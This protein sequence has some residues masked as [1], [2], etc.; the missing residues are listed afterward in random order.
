M[1]PVDA[2]CWIISVRM[3]A[4]RVNGARAVERWF[5]KVLAAAVS[6]SVATAACASGNDTLPPLT[7][8]VR[9]TF[10]MFD[11]PLGIE[12]GTT[13]LNK[14]QLSGTL[15]GDQFGLDGWSVHAQLFRF[16][17]QSLSRRLGD[18]QTADNIETV[19][20]TRLFEAYV[21]R[22][23]GRNNHSIAVRAGFIDLNSQFD[24]IDAASMM[25][26][27]SHG[28]GP[29]L[30]LSGRNGPSIYPVTAL[31]STI[32]WVHSPTW[33]FRLG[34]FEALPKTLIGLAHSSRNGL[35]RTMARSSLGSWTSRSRR[36]AG[37]R[38]GFGPI[39]QRKMDPRVRT[40]TIREP[41]F[42]PRRRWTS[43]LT[44][45]SGF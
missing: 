33:T 11:V 23:S 37:L 26:S 25:L 4:T 3:A 40:R 30:S 14:I 43:C 6:A 16:D 41:I 12:P 32:T 24:P 7:I 13:V 19:P 22:L 29:D 20:V 28:I 5:A 1:V 21:T 10:D 27:S 2:R 35:S 34:M 31:G 17:G 38:P 15:R 42:P 8:A 39:W 36:K 44:S 9:N 18:I 45:T